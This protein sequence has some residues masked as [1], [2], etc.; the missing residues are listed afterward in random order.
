MVA[1]NEE[2]DA[3]PGI[4]NKEP[5]GEGWIAKI[6][7]KEE[8]EGEGGEGGEGERLMDEEEYKR[9]TA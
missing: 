9:F 1:A 3:K 8:E 5:E 2:L 6:E 7:L 4:I